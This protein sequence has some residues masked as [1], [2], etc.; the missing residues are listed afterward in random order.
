MTGKE[1]QE[2]A[3]LTKNHN[4]TEMLETILRSTKLGVPR[5]YGSI[6]NG[7]LGLSG[8]VGEF[9]DTIKK[10]IFH[11]KDTSIEHCKKELGDVLWYVA[12]ICDAFE[13]DMDEIMQMNIDKLASRYSD[14]FNVYESNNRKAGDI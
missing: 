6:I 1:Y 8:E 12:L 14:G 9:V 13:W 11:N 2:L 10:F 7:C 5:D 3:M 4:S